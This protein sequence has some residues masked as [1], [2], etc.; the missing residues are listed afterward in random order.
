M[1]PV[2]TRRIILLL[3]IVT[4]VAAFA[5][6][7]LPHVGRSPAQ[8]ALAELT[9]GVEPEESAYPKLGTVLRTRAWLVSAPG[10]P[11]GI[12]L[13]SDLSDAEFGRERVVTPSDLRATL[14][15]IHG[16]S[17]NQAAQ[18]WSGDGRQVP[19]ADVRTLLVAAMPTPTDAEAIIDLL[20][21]TPSPGTP[22]LS[23]LLQAE[24]PALEAIRIVPFHG[25]RGRLLL[26]RGRPPY[27]AVERGYTG[28]M[29]GFTGTGWP[30]E[31]RV[32][33]LR[34]IEP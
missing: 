15:R 8:T 2:S 9:L 22:A 29:V 18:A 10:Q 3:A 4:V 25:D 13:F 14:R 20:L 32:L 21:G 33:R 26:D 11:D 19:I 27:V 1:I 28:L 17:W 30:T 6:S 31:W 34:G 5:L 12:D 16:L 24:R 23:S 7:R